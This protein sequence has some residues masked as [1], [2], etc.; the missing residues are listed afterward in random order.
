MV[1]FDQRG[2]TV[3]YQYNAAGNINIGNVRNIAMLADQLNALVH[4]VDLATAQEVLPPEAG[5][6]A[7]HALKK[8]SLEAAK[9]H[10]DKSSILSYLKTAQGLVEGV[11]GLAGAIGAAIAKIHGLS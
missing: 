5:L 7:Q 10:P 2:Q 3:T 6:D 4:E 1:V 9:S 11:G 8:A